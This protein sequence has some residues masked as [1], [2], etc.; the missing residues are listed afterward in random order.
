MRGVL[1]WWLM[2]TN[3]SKHS[4]TPNSGCK[5][6]GAHTFDHADPGRRRNDSRQPEAGRFKER[7]ELVLR[8]LSPA[9]TDQHVDIIGGR[10][11]APIRGIDARWIDALND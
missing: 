9:S 3:S 4:A 7:T 5:E 2:I 10:A 1:P 6:L 11:T 8:A